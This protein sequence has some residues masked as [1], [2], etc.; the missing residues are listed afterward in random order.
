MMADWDPSSVGG[1]QFDPAS[2]G[3]VPV[4][5]PSFTGPSTSQ[6]A[7]M[8]TS[9]TEAAHRFQSIADE[10]A[11][12]KEQDAILANMQNDLVR[13][14][15]G[16]GAHTTND[17][18]KIVQ[19]WTPNFAK[20]LGIDP[21][22][23]GAQESFDKLANQLVS[24]ANPGS[25]ARQGVLQGAT[26]SSVQSPEGVDFILRQLRGMNDYRLARANLA[27][28]SAEAQRGDYPSWQKNVGNTLSPQVFQFNRLTPSQKAD[29]LNGI[30]EGERAS[31]KKQFLT[32]KAA[33]FHGV[34]YG[35]Q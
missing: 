13:F 7:A 14:T 23:I 5:P 8:Q 26:P 2:V 29:F 9:G 30:P 20:F 35:G 32:T 24:S 19:S 3:G 34:D 21:S 22:K 17:L 11:Q 1:V 12:A 15:S 28:G 27:A 33:G 25:D 6:S 18:Q 10:G 4:Q 31:F 16:P